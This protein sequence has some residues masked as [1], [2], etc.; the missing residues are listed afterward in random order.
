M[1]LSTGVTT[2][3]L[4]PEHLQEF[5][6]NSV[7]VPQL[8][9]IKLLFLLFFW[10]KRFFWKIYGHVYLAPCCTCQLPAPSLRLG[11]LGFWVLCLSPLKAGC[12]GIVKYQ[13]SD[14]S[15]PPHHH[16][17]SIITL[18]HLFDRNNS[19]CL[20]KLHSP[21]AKQLGP[22]ATNPRGTGVWEDRAQRRS[23]CLCCW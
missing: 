17:Q 22:E 4:R 8:N 11:C 9:P 16:P 13:K 18:A 1:W 10:M 20:P 12:L 14:L 23:C 2:C 7:E 6:R 19:F 21:V 15:P 3:S 5:R